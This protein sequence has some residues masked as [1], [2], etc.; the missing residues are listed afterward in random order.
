M[1]GL[2]ELLERYRFDESSEDALQ[3]GVA[4]VLAGAALAFTREVP[5]S[6]QDRIDFLVL[7]GVGIECKTKGSLS[8]LVRQL[9]RYALASQVDAL[10]VV[11]A[12]A[13][14]AR[15]PPLLNGKP[16]AVVAT[17]GGLR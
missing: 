10:V 15:L 12:R 13:Q 3:R 5:L 17:M 9:H 6:R 2:V 8:A 7:G 16:I 4:E 11:T 1:S 14:L